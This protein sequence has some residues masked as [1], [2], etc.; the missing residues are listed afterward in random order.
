MSH[1]KP[2]V[3][4]SIAHDDV[5]RNVKRTKVNYVIALKYGGT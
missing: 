3:V 4:T 5:K 1:K 2:I